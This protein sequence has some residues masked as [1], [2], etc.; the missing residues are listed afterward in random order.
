MIPRIEI[1]ATLSMALHG[2]RCVLPAEVAAELCRTWL[3]VQGALVAKACEVQI[4]A[5]NTRLL[6]AICGDRAGAAALQGRRVRLVV[7][8]ECE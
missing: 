5:S 8:D 2:C 7:E 3:A 6:V 1:E 4:S